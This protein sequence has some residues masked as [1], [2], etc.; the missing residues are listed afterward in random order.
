[1]LVYT[2]EQVISNTGVKHRV[3]LIGHNVDAVLIGH[4]GNTTT[5]QS[6]IDG[7]KKLQYPLR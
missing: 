3:V 4:G 6:V 5:A 7:M 1:M 2:P